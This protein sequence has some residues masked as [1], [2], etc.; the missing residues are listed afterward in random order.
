[1]CSRLSVAGFGREGLKQSA[2]SK[3]AATA[4]LIAVKENLLG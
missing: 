1:V 3:E 4:I 2:R